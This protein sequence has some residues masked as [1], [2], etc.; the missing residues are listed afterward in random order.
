MELEGKPP[1]GIVADAGVVNIAWEAAQLGSDLPCGRTEEAATI[2]P[3]RFHPTLRTWDNQPDL[4][5]AYGRT[6]GADPPRL[7]PRS[8]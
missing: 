2:V 4:V 6:D 3:L 5:V 1:A 8:T 7:E